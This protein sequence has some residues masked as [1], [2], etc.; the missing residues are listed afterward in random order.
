MTDLRGAEP[1][2]LCGSLSACCKRQ[3]LFGIR[4][5]ISFD[6]IIRFIILSVVTKSFDRTVMKY[7]PFGLDERSIWCEVP[8][9]LLL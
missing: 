3:I 2:S 9:N 4:I 5:S 8:V 1:I 7:I 6:T